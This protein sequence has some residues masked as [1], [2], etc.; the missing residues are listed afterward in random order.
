MKRKCVIIKSGGALTLLSQKL[1]GGE[2]GC[3]SQVV[4]NCV[5]LLKYTCHFVTSCCIKAESASFFQ[6]KIYVSAGGSLQKLQGS[7][8][9]QIKV[10]LDNIV[11]GTNVKFLLGKTL[12]LSNCMLPL[13]LML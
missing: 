2:G 7:N 1:W 4:K 10:F 13:E 9:Y 8:D 11:D 3:C 5:G 6:C 12:Y